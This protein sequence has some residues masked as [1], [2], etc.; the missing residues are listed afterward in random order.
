[1][2]PDE[3]VYKALACLR[4]WAPAS[5][6]ASLVAERA[7][8]PLPD[9]LIALRELA[10]ADQAKRDLVGKWGRVDRIREIWLAKGSHTPFPTDM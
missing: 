3:I 10:A 2:A 9:V 8:L 5:L 1:M 6:P 4:E 7:G